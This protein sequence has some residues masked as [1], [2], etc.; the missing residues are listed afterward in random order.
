MSGHACLPC[1]RV[2]SDD[3]LARFFQTLGDIRYWRHNVEAE[4]LRHVS[5]GLDAGVMSHRNTTCD[6][7]KI[8]VLFVCAHEPDLKSLLSVSES[9]A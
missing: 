1:S 4:A 6:D 5:I 3:S 7:I 8:G 2:R 9:G